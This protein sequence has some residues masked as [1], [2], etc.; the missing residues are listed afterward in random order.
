M[1]EG[2]ESTKREKKESN[3]VAEFLLKQAISRLSERAPTTFSKN[4]LLSR[5]SENAS[6]KLGHFYVLSINPSVR[7]KK[8]HNPSK[9][10]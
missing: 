9:L 1:L 10:G 5:S 8:S 7:R 2:P 3:P 4:R 6:E